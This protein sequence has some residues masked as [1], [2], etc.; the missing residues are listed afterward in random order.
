MP[1]WA[2]PSRSRVRGPLNPHERLAPDRC[3]APVN[4]SVSATPM[5]SGASCRM[6]GGQARGPGKAR[7]R[8]WVLSLLALALACAAPR[9]NAAAEGADPVYQHVVQKARALAAEPYQESDPGAVPEVLRD[10]DYQSYRDIRFSKER[11]LWQE[12]GLF[13]VELFHPGFLYN[14][15]VTLHEVVDGEV[16]TIRYDPTLFDHGDN[17]GLDT[18]ARTKLSYAGFRVHF[19]IERADYRDEVITFLGASY[20]RMVGAGQEYGLSARGL[21]IDTASG[22][23]EEFP[24]FTEFWLRRPGPEQTSMTFFA[25][26]QSPSVAGAYRFVLTPGAD[27]VLDVEARLF[28]RRDIDKLGVAPLTS[29]FLYGENRTRAFDDYRPE[30]HDSDGLLVHHGD[31]GWTWRPLSN[32]RQLR[33]STL[34]D[35]KPRGFGLAQ[36]DRDFE[37]YLDAE[38]GYHQ[39][40]GYWVTPRGGDWGRGGVQLIEI[41]TDT[42]AHDNIVAFWTPEA[43]FQAGQERVFKY[44]LRTFGD[45]PGTPQLATVVRTRSGTNA[46]SSSAESPPGRQRQFMVDFAGATLAALHDS[47]P[48][49]ARL[50]LRN[51]ELHEVNAL[52]LPAG[53]G[54]RAA[55][56]LTPDGDRPVDIRLHLDLRGRPLSETWSYVWYPETD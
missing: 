28:A 45:A 19:P 8:C 25:L 48:V 11:A 39:R 37:H 13:S 35:D 44:R 55:F 10:L 2:S 26:L 16:R 29:M 4:A 41:P 12:Q 38:A 7:R 46:I 6:T 24:R 9:V 40:P 23:G 15:P 42:E 21:A 33:V 3:H 17:R 5:A 20:F 14:D 31:G 49:R 43:T 51:G 36:R 52:R 53:Q 50:S 34:L 22:G 18:V 32:G 1:V 27:T 47:Q 30:V 54:W 56:T